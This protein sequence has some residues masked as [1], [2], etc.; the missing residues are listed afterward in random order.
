LRRFQ[1]E[2]IRIH[3]L[4]A[5]SQPP[6]AVAA[7]LA[8]DL[9]GI[10]EELVGLRTL[11]RS[12]LDPPPAVRKA[13]GA[14]QLAAAYTLA[15]SRLALMIRIERELSQERP[16]DTS[17]KD[18]LK[19]VDDRAQELNQP[20]KSPAI[21]AEVYGEDAYMGIADRRLM[22]EIAATR[23][24][25]RSTLALASDELKA[26]ATIRLV[27]VYGEGCVRLVRLLKAGRVDRGRLAAYI[28]ESWDKAIRAV[29]EELGLS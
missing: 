4:Y 12:L 10:D 1:S 7:I 24:V 3:G 28:E 19:M 2:D 16:E 5:R 15:A 14:T 25:L 13:A 22:E 21:L 6:E 9:Q 17:A 23:Y 8:E 11:A 20:P 26:S 27:E 29:T 18:Y